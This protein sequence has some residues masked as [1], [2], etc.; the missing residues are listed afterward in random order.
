MKRVFPYSGGLW[1]LQI[2]E[3]GFGELALSNRGGQINRV[4]TLALSLLFQ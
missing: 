3:T 4:L 1:V 2:V